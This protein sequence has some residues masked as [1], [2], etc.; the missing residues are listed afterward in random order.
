MFGML[1]AIAV[2]VT[3]GASIIAWH[4]N[5]KTENEL[6]R[7]ERAYR[8]RDRMYDEYHSEVDR[9]QKHYS[10]AQKKQASKQRELLLDE[11]KI[12][13]EKIDP[14]KKAYDQLYSL[15]L[16]E[17]QADSTSPYR[18]SALRREFAQIQDGQMRLSEYQKYLNY[19]RDRVEKAWESK[20]LDDL[21]D[22]LPADA[23]LPMEWLY[24]GKLVMVDWSDIGKRQPKFGHKLS[25]NGFPDEQELQKSLA[26]AYGDEFPML[27]YKRGKREDTFYGCVARGIA[28]HDHIRL[29][30]PLE[31]TVDR[32]LSQSNAYLCHAY[33]GILKL[34]LPKTNLLHPSLRCIQG[35]KFDVY[36][37]SFDSK[38]E[39]DPSGKKTNQ[40]HKPNV[41]VTE[42]PPADV[43]QD[44]LGLYIAIDNE[45]LRQIPDESGFYDHSTVW[46]VSRYCYETQMIVLCKGNIHLSCLISDAKDGL[47][48]DKIQVF[49]TPQTGIDLPF[50]FIVTTP[51]I[52]AHK[53]FGWK[54]GVEQLFSFVS[55]S[56]VDP[57][58][59][60]ERIKQAEFFKR[61]QKV[62]NYQKKM[63]SERE[64]EFDALLQSIDKRKSVLTVPKAIIKPLPSEDTTVLTL[65]K[66]IEKTM[67]MPKHFACKLEFWDKDQSRY[68]PAIEKHRRH[69]AEY[70]IIDGEIIISGHFLEYV[71]TDSEQRF[72]FTVKLPNSA[73]QRQEQ[74][75]NALFED[76]LEE[77]R[78]KD[79]FLSPARYQAENIPR[80]AEHKI[81]WNSQL[82]TSQQLAVEKA[83][84]AKHLAMIQGPPG[85]GKTTTIVEMLYQLFKQDPNLKILVV[86]QQNTAVDNALTKF[87]KKYP[88]LIKDSIHVIRVGNPDKLDDDILE[89]HFDY[90]Y[91]CFLDE[92]I[93]AATRNCV[94]LDGRLRD[95]SLEWVSL[96]KQMKESSESHRVS[97]EFFTT[98]LA[99]KNLVG[100]TCVGLA[101]R[102]AGVDHLSF[103]IAIV[104]EAGRATVPEL[105][106]PLLR[107]RKAI[108]IGD[109]HQL[110]PSIAPVL[111]ED[112]A[113]EEL[114]F[115]EETFLETS[116]FEMLFEQLPEDC[117]A[118]LAEQFRMAPPIG[119]L[120]AELFYTKNG[121]RRLF[122]GSNK[123]IDPDSA[124]I[125]DSL[126]WVDVW[127]KQYKAEGTTSI[128]NEDEAQAICEYLK[129]LSEKVDRPIDVAVITPYGAQKR[130]IRKKLSRDGHRQQIQLGSLSIKVDTVDSFQGSEA[131]LVCYSTVRTW[132]SLQF[133]LDKKRLNVACSRAKENLVFFGNKRHLQ[134]ASGQSGHEN[135]FR[136]IIRRSVQIPWKGKKKP[137]STQ[138]NKPHSKNY[139]K[140]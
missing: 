52:D 117:T 81:H 97:D 57:E 58:D 4:F 114:E 112:A 80:W 23:L 100:A 121:E 38:L 77:P 94:T 104:D 42:K 140:A 20:R 64:V 9:I 40:K 119:D 74:A 103:D 37:D 13:T 72:R 26:L 139:E 34:L 126:V 88:H 86:S 21:M 99:N 69:Q 79:I 96:L 127:G 137:R 50:S 22:M 10:A 14:I 66:Q 65:L 6:R 3:V 90:L 15:I 135:L 67:T 108:L 116:F 76:R 85:T 51:D 123:E 131:E 12:H 138:T 39:C 125:P 25:F 17:I 11:I 84:K 44:D 95:A 24:P 49:D 91:N 124:I 27:V 28:F 56:L 71:D 98:M 54:Y 73:L 43:G 62:V 36:F 31:I 30:E 5:R 118:S 35:Q 78:L 41:T 68:L 63:E 129:S 102:K 8:A 1:S 83:L 105:L 33:D 19:E 115:L 111:R 55:Q 93:E 53:L 59:S 122:N 136:E 107:S 120:V 87:K 130:L 92:K 48:V 60:Q 133:L 106:I 45:H 128:H 75:L 110:P 47:T 89:D 70:E 134:K 101:A 132:G 29:G 2:G 32:H 7:Q 109:H 16:E 113:K 61:W 82:T 46:T 18:K